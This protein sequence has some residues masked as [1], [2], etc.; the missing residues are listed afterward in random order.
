M[1]MHTEPQH[2]RRFQ[3]SVAEAS[4]TE[5]R[6]L[7]GAGADRERQL[8]LSRVRAAGHSLQLGAKPVDG[9]LRSCSRLLASLRRGA[10]R[11]R[12]VCVPRKRKTRV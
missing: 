8:P 12:G 4:R 11:L 3:S 5:L 6:A 1:Q 2:A 7:H 9:A 10:R